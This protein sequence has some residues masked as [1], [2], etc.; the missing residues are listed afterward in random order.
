MEHGS[1]FDKMRHKMKKYNKILIF[2]V[3]VLLIGIVLAF[4]LLYL[5]SR[6]EKSGYYYIDPKG[7]IINS[8]PYAQIEKNLACF[9]EEGIAL[10]Y[11]GED[12]AFFVDREG[13]VIGK[14]NFYKDDLSLGEKFSFPIITREDGEIV[15]LDDKLNK[16]GQLN[17]DYNADEVI[18]HS[19]FS[20]G[21][22]AVSV[23]ED[24]NRVW[25]FINASGDWVIE[26]KYSAADLFSEGLARVRN[27]ENDLCGYI[28][29]EGN[30]IID[31]QFYDGSSFC[32]GYAVVQKEDDGKNAYI[33]SKG[34]YITDYLYE[35]DYDKA[36][37]YFYDGLAAVTPYGEEKK[38]YIN[39]Q[40]EVA[41]DPDSTVAYRFSQG[42]AF[43]GV[44]KFI[45][46]NGKV[47]IDTSDNDDCFYDA[48][49]FL[50]DGYSVVA[51]MTIEYTKDGD[52][53]DE[54]GKKYKIVNKYGVID[55]N[56]DWIYEPQFLEKASG[57]NHEVTPP[58]HKDGYFL[59]Y[60]EKGQRIKKSK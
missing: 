49:P 45:D 33:N 37:K 27:S 11:D 46:T 26:P 53:S 44:G 56:G 19:T 21:L 40:G 22:G 47:V 31:Y 16:I 23:V 55:T 14:R 39:E 3:A 32:D 29:T 38:V 12:K 48:A 25:G 10:I 34:E 35:A 13:K 17:G 20:E 50:A 8:S 4:K 41:I 58:R 24:G 59:V 54:K 1:G 52:L 9:S 42:L 15:I 18:F 51:C 7:N 2:I 57:S 6:V 28:D 43:V 36:G 60:L 30:L 5:D